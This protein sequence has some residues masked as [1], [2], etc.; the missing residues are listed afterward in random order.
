MSQDPVELAKGCILHKMY[1]HN[2][3]G[4]VH[5]PIERLTKGKPDEFAPHI[6]KAFNKLKTEG[7]IRRKPA[8]YGKQ[9]Y[10]V[11][12]EKGYAYANAYQR[13]ANLPVADY[14]APRGPPPMPPPLTPEQMK[15]LKISAKK[16]KQRRA[17][18]SN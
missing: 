4:G 16:M 10:A 15:I 11:R 14:T 8:G 12:C 1:L 7:I 13:Y 17:T 3:T 5:R 6:S 18:H 9:Y 2:I